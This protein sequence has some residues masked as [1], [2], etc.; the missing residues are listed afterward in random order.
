MK[1]IDSLVQVSLRVLVPLIYLLQ[2][3]VHRVDRKG[4]IVVLIAQSIDFFLL[5]I[6]FFILGLKDDVETRELSVD[7]IMLFQ[8]YGVVF[9]K[10]TVVQLVNLFE[11]IGFFQL[12]LQVTNIS[13]QAITLG[14][15]Y[16]NLESLLSNQLC[17]FIYSVHL[18]IHFVLHPTL[19]QHLYA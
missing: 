8:E 4:E 10:F 18:Q 9:S 11:L 17:V 13:L 1:P 15:N 2:F 5:R 16:I 3:N 14:F 6:D 7:D 12:D 19:F